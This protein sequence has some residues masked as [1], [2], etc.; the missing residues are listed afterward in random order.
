M[1]RTLYGLSPSPWT[2]RARWA[3]DHHGVAYDYHEHV[4]MLGEVLLRAKARSAK[5]SV[6]LLADG[7]QVVMGSVAIARHA[8]RVGRG[9]A[10]FPEG[11]EEEIASWVDRAERMMDVGRAWLVKRML[12]SKDAQIEQLPPFIPGPLRS[13]S[14]PT[15]ALG[16]KFL[17]KKYG[18][19]EDVDAEVERTLRPLLQELRTGIRQHQKVDGPTWLAGGAFSVIDLVLATT[20]Q[21]VRPHVSAKLGPATRE[22]WTNVALVADFGDLLEW[23][24]AIYAAHR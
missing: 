2:E 11:K 14:A 1:S 4:P 7:D 8:D 21:V 9:K 18:V 12:K 19:P 3:L 5:A 23:R 17:A 6:P 16:L 22:A 20:M 13:V 10:L 15:A 24:D